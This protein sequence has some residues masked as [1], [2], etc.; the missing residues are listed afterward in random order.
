MKRTFLFLYEDLRIGGIENNLIRM[1]RAYSKIGMRIIWIRYGK[2]ESIYEPW[3]SVLH[4]CGVE[5]VTANANYPNWFSF[6]RIDFENDEEITAVCFD[7]FDFVRL[8]QFCN[9]YKNKI[10]THYMVPHFER[11]LN[12]VEEYFFGV[13]TKK[14]IKSRLK[15]IYSEWYRN[16]NILFFNQ[17]H[18]EEMNIRYEIGGEDSFREKIYE[19]PILPR[20]FDSKLI[21][22][23][24]CRNE[25]RI[26]T[27][28]RFDFPHKGYM[29][30]LIDDY[31][32]LKNKYANIKLDII[33][34]GTE[35]NEKRIVSYVNRLQERYRKDIVFHGSVNPDKISELFD[36]ANVNVSVSGGVVDGAMCGVASIP[37]RHYCY[38]CEVYGGGGGKYIVAD[39]PGVD[40][41]PLI[42][43]A[44]HMTQ[45][46]YEEICRLSYDT[47]IKDIGDIDW[48]FQ[49]GN[50]MP[51]YYSEE[52]VAFFKAIFSYKEK[53][54]LI[55]NGI[56]KIPYLR[57]FYLF[58][59]NYKNS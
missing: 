29:F 39:S 20:P 28:G 30:G 47:V 10:T 33:G 43:Q 40:V 56:K 44:I 45:S 9:G 26:I 59:R 50:R 25:F 12:Y 16:G 57:Q 53:I 7:P 1:I 5:I 31:V 32:I 54:R 13:V 46:K 21:R 17:R 15:K 41:K 19:A 37:A 8:E 49:R 52:D 23:K 36:Q 38:K 14:I 11:K 55:K 24:C 3:K 22:D 48:L 4:D 34:Y 18:W 6:D 51:S 2:P 35:R 42:E 27:C 58:L